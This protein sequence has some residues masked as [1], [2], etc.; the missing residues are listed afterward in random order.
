MSN[1]ITVDIVTGKE[2]QSVYFDPTLAIGFSIPNDDWLGKN[3]FIPASVVATHEGE[4]ILTVKTPAGES[5]KVPLSTASY[6]TSNDDQGVDDILK[7][8]RFSEMSLI[9]NLR[10]RYYQDKIYTFVGPILISINPY[11]W[12]SNQY[13]EETMTEY[14]ARHQVIGYT[15][16][17]CD[18][19]GKSPCSTSRHHTSS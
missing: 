10:L 5:F 17:S 14:H 3:L 13:S 18:A 4:D 16:I 6:V 2:L 12:L 1:R 19:E 8:A 7:L 15:D 11:K 9:H